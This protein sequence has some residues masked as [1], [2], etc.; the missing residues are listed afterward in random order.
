M[1]VDVLYAQGVHL[2]HPVMPDDR[3]I[4]AESVVSIY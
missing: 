3:H 4:Q 1:D 2:L